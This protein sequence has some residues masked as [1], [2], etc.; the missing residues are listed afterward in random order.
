MLYHL[1]RVTKMCHELG[2]HPMIWSDMFFRMVTPD[3]SYCSKDVEI[4]QDVIDKVPDGLTLVF[5]DYNSKY[6]PSFDHMVDCHLK[7]KNNDIAFA[8]GAW[9]WSSFS[10]NNKFSIRYS[11]FQLNICRK[12]G[13]N[14]VIVTCWGDDGSEAAQFSALAAIAYFAEAGYR[15]GLTDERLNERCLEAL[16]ISYDDLLLM[17]EANQMPGVDQGDVI[18][19]PTRY[20]LFNDPLEGLCDYHLVPGETGKAFGENAKT[21]ERLASH[22]EFGYMYDTLAK[23]CYA[24]EIK[25][26]LSYNLKSAYKAGNRAY[27]E[28]AANRIIP[29]IIS[30]I[31]DFVCAYRKQWYYENKTFG[32][33]N[34]EVRIGGQVARLESAIIRLKAYLAGETDRI[35][36][37]EQPILPFSKQTFVDR[38]YPYIRTLHWRKIATVGVMQ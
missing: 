9:K 16:G 33:T 30:R 23:L 26:E 27:L 29:E 4:S 24:L 18:I 6:A 17:D 3:G 8:G 19:T 21:L 13:L 28:E 25:A 37:L 31:G 14:N 38:A 7:F 11:E 32:F 12:K 36:E 35:E 22:S 10:A 20:L 15:D 1:D 34:Q 2:Y 5:W